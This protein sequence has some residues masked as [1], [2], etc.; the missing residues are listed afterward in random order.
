MSLGVDQ[1]ET[2]QTPE[3]SLNLNPGSYQS[4]EW[5]SQVDSRAFPGSFVHPEVNSS[6]CC[7]RGSLPSDQYGL[8]APGKVG[9]PGGPGILSQRQELK[10]LPSKSQTFH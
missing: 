1:S 7:E 4:D 10:T 2:P 8:V 9:P 3:A 5:G 6:S